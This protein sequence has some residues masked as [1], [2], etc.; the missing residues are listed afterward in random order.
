MV[1][2]MDT[3]NFFCAGDDLMN[4]IPTI[5]DA[6][7]QQLIQSTAEHFS[8]VT[9]KQGFQY[10]K[11]G[12]VRSTDTG[13][14]GVIDA[15]VQGKELYR[16]RLNWNSLEDSE[17]SCPVSKDCKHIVAVMMA[18]AQALGRSVHALANAHAAGFRSAVYAGQAAEEQ[19][20]RQ[21]ES[22]NW[23]E[24][25]E[26]LAEQPISAWYELF[27]LCTASLGANANNSFYVKNALSSLHHIKPPLPAALDPLYELNAHLFVL[28]KLLKQPNAWASS[29]TYLGYHTHIAA[30][31]LLRVIG[32]IMA[33]GLAAAE[34]EAYRPRLDETLNRIRQHMLVE[35][36]NRKYYAH[37]YI[38][39][40]LH[41]K[42]PLHPE[43]AAY[44]DE[45]RH[46]QA[47]EAELGTALSKTHWLI[48]QGLM[49][50]YLNRDDEALAAME[51]TRHQGDLPAGPILHFF[52][53]LYNEA[54][55]ERLKRWLIRLGPMLESNI[56]DH[57][58][59]YHAYWQAVVEQSPDALGDMWDTLRKML[60]YSMDIYQEALIYYEE[61]RLWI[62]LQLSLKKEP[63]QFRVSEL[64]PIE[65]NAPELLLPFY[66]QAVERYILHKNRDGYKAAVKLLKRL[67]KLYKR[68]KRQERWDLFITGLSV[69]HSRLRA[70]QEELR[71][72]KLL[73]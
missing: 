38:Q 55:W 28:G 29:G 37:T 48:A 36:R 6:Q 47:A 51:E 66:H 19:R 52:Q 58:R 71:R 41:W 32:Q 4:S 13:E 33:G 62:D 2:L 18:Y 1:D 44:E 30:D 64:Q 22:V 42:R 14:D 67:A 20:L 73:S 54:Q 65:K 70:F 17:C 68:L 26:Q 43:P 5:D 39:F 60:P 25:A 45:L 46:L 27:E 34:A 56:T 49:H 16:V 3:Q 9:I 12:R 69:R 7:W 59:G 72:G 15:E 10:F 53:V 23:R 21:A 11:L 57:M 61:W 31:Q 63:L 8:D 24:K 40:W 50:F 35:P